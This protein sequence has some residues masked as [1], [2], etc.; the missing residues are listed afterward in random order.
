MPRVRERW[1]V[2]VPEYRHKRKLDAVWCR[3][4]KVSEVFNKGEKVKLGIP[5]SF[6]GL[7]VFNRDNIRVR[8]RFYQLIGKTGHR[9]LIG[10]YFQ[11][12]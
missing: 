9:Q 6:D 1:W 2:L 10:G 11:V 5:A 4:Y 8:N 7:W 3:P 12:R